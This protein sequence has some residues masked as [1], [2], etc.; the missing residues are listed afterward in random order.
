MCNCLF[1]LFCPN[2]NQPRVAYP[3]CQP[4]NNGCGCGGYNQCQNCPCNALFAQRNA[5]LINAYGP[6]TVSFQPPLETA[7][8]VYQYQGTQGGTR[9]N[10]CCC[11]CVQRCHSTLYCLNNL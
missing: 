6:S 11:G 2:Y 4:N 3:N 10:G 8:Y 9:N 5:N 7:P 1:N